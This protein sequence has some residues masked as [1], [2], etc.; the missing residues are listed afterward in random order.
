[1]PTPTSRPA[2]RARPPLTPPPASQPATSPRSTFPPRTPEH[3]HPRTRPA[4]HGHSRAPV[5]GTTPGGAPDDHTQRSSTIPARREPDDQPV[6]PRGDPRPRRHHRPAHP[7][8]HLRPGPVA[9][10]PDGAHRGMGAG[11]R[12]EE[13]TSELQSQFHLVCRLLLEKKKQVR[14]WPLLCKKKKNNDMI[15]SNIDDN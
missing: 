6:D 4:R 11:R 8:L 3:P 9:V 14:S 15:K 5:P 13:H 10:L 1:M 12:S 7:R 2:S